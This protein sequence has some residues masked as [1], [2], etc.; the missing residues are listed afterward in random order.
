M[1]EII[2]IR[3]GRLIDPANGRDEAADLFIKDG[4]IAAHLTA[5]EKSAARL[6]EAAGQVVSPGFVDI[7]VHLRE[8]GQTHKETIGTGT[9]AAAAGGFTSVVCM[10]NTTPPVDNTGTLRLVL[11]SAR[12]Q[13]VV[14]VYPTGAITK[15]L[16]GEA[17]APIGS[18]KM[19]G[20]VAITDDGQCVQNNELMRRAV[21]YSRLFDLPI[22]DHCQDRSLT[23][24]AVMN[25]GQWS[26]RL[27]L[28]GWPHAA[29]DI[30]VARNAILAAMTGG[31]IHI[32]HLSSARAVE[33]VRRAK[34]EGIRLTAEATPHHLSL[35]DETCAGYD[36]NF[37]M[38][39]P[40]RTEA[41]RQAILD[42][43]CDGTIDCL[44]TDHAPHSRDDKDK[45]FDLAPFGIT[46]LETALPVCLGALV[47]S[48]RATLS[49]LVGWL[50]HRPAALLKLPVG[51]LTVGAEADVTVFDPAAEWVADPNGWQSLS[52][53]SPWN[54]C[55]LQG[56]V[57]A[58]LVGGRLVWDGRKIVEG[59]D[60]L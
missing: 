28:R 4:R 53:N 39:P 20:A 41:D 51:S 33:L 42:G 44:A 37:K 21:E 55:R 54:G 60:P 47:R 32:Q 19:A 40:L 30:I 18:L 25:E 16:K 35:T 6:L 52:A 38:N 13:A 59:H 12:T 43:L 36:T 5:E 27:G 56:R 15:E 31:H 34:A 11:E 29:E 14:R 50:T 3:G 57:T 26:L 48:G 22:L 23:E 7:H 46:G 45:E 10:P 9:R 2:W 49:Q 58:T 17:L 24:G 8:P 1:S